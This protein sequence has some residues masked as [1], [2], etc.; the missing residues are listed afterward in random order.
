M[1]SLRAR[2]ALWAYRW[3]GVVAYPAINTL[4]AVRS[5]RGKEERARR[6]ERY[7]YASAPRPEGPLVW[8]HAAS[9]GETNAMVPLI[10]EISRRGITVLLTTGTVTSAT[11]VNARLSGYVIHQYVP[12]DLKTVVER[13]LEYW[14]PDLALF[15]ESEIWPNTIMALGRRH[16]PQILVNA[17]MSDRS[18]RRWSSFPNV[19][20][21][22]F[23]NLA[24]VIAQSELDASRMQDLGALPVLV[25]GNLKA[26]SDMPEADAVALMRLRQQI[27]GRSTWAAIST[28][29]GEEKAAGQVHKAL[30]SRLDLLSIVVPRHPERGDD[31]EAL[32]KEQ[33]LTVA[34]RS[35]GDQIAADTDIYLGDTIGEMSLYLQL[36]EVAFVG[37][38]LTAEGGQNPLEPAMMGCAILSGGHVGN[39]RESYQMLARNGS[40]RMV[41]DTEMLAKGVYYLI[42]NEP[43]RHQM[44]DAGLQT[45]HQM[46]GA[47]S[48]TLRGLEP[49]INPLTMKARLMPRASA[50][51]G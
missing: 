38:S 47:L 2:A 4:V 3:A 35:R 14:Q 17:R 50:N 13:F 11:V 32:F 10:K 48:A 19:A 5:A 40:A 9:V 45:V 18:F 24:L 23:E 33:G 12:L 22:L 37:R 29:D 51:G 27:G 30:K 39:F 6:S 15:A 36:T 21:A 49:Y 41:R 25:S 16:I 44:I 31:I 26:D 46:R 1:S 8:V 43:A 34:R 42:T 28:F 7:G 20:S